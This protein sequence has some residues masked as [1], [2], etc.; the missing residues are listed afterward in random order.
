M[1]RAVPE[2][3]S[4]PSGGQGAS[5]GDKST[6]VIGAP[7]KLTLSLRV[8][9]RRADGYHFLDMTVGFIHLADRLTLTAPGNG[10]LTV[11]GPTADAVDGAESRADNM[12]L[13]AGNLLAQWAGRALGVDFHLDK[14]IP[15]AAGLGG[16]SADAAACLAALARH[17]RLGIDGDELASLAL[18]LGADVPV[19][20][21]GGAS[22]VEGI[23]DILTPLPAMDAALV[24]VNP[25]VALATPAVFRAF[26]EPFSAPNDRPADPATWRNDLT[27]TARGL[28]PEIGLALDALAERSGVGYVGM[29]GSGATCFAVM[30]SA[31]RAETAASALAADHPGWWVR[32]DRLRG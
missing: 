26:G 8:T 9:G 29:A 5:G 24:L 32:A 27:Q 6:I 31:M 21:A 3:S 14:H 10:A 17:W 28:A 20:L 30:E 12:V 4:P 18:R 7:A 13:R 23:G 1:A 2:R 22:R 19:C 25:G 16:G 15:V 11:S